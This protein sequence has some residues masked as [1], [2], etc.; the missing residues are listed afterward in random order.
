MRARGHAHAGTC[1]RAPTRGSCSFLFTHLQFAHLRILNLLTYLLTH[2]FTHKQLDEAVE[3]F[4]SAGSLAAK[5]GNAFLEGRSML[6]L[7]QVRRMQGEAGRTAALEA[8]T[9]ALQIAEKFKDEDGNQDWEAIGECNTRLAA[10]HLDIGHPELALPLLEKASATWLNFCES[11]QGEL[12]QLYKEGEAHVLDDREW[13]EIMEEH[14]DTGVLLQEALIAAKPD[15]PLEA[16]FASEASRCPTMRA[17]I[18]LTSSAADAAEVADISDPVDISDGAPAVVAP[19]AASAAPELICTA[20]HLKEVMSHLVDSNARGV[21]LYYAYLESEPERQGIP[22]PDKDGKQGS[23][24]TVCVWVIDGSGSL[25][26]FRK[27]AAIGRDGR[28]FHELY[29]DLNTKTAVYAEAQVTRG[30]ASPASGLYSA[31]LDLT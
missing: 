9:R 23:R 19:S 2:L 25:L 21:L 24:D 13:V 20:E 12:Q 4:K 28:S 6:D 27:S 30:P 18:H 17:I 31:R 15:S 3:H 10:V 16:L 22:H 1:M 8:A 29:S 5:L 26:A 7:A 14:S 11:K